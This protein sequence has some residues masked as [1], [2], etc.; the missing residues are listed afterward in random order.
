M[1]IQSIPQLAQMSQAGIPTVNGPLQINK[2]THGWCESE[3]FYLSLF[4]VIGQ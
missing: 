2:W 1:I 4:V 3:K